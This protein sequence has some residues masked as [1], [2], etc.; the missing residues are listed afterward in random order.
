MMSTI[1]Y[2]L[3]VFALAFL[4]M[5]VGVIFSNRCIKGSCGGI[6]N[7]DGMEGCSECG[8]CSIADKKQKQADQMSAAGSCPVEDEK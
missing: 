8:G 5:A 6:A 3:G 2:A 4:G 7:L 1:L